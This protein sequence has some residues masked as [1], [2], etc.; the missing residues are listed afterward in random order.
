MN[1]C[2]SSIVLVIFVLGAL[3]APAQDLGFVAGAVFNRL[4]S[5]GDGI[6]SK[7]EVASAREEMFDRIDTDRDGIITL[8]EIEA[9]KAKAQ[10]RQ[11]SR[12]ARLA[13][14]HAKETR[15]PS[16]RFAALDQNRDGK[17]SRQEFVSVSPW[18]DR[19]AKNGRGISKAELRSSMPN[20]ATPLPNPSERKHYENR[21]HPDCDDIGPAGSLGRLCAS[22][23]LDP[24]LDRPLRR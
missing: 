8:G 2:L 24:E 9:A 22:R 13:A 6:L 14:L 4:D 5:N 7:E 20:E 1:P 15:T 3:A 17:V 23:Q 10:E 12:L 21:H 19:I 11:L 16:E 18:F